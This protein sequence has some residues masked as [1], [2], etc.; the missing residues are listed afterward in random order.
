MIKTKQ[1]TLYGVFQL[2]GSIGEISELNTQ[3]KYFGKK[4]G[5]LIQ[6]C[7]TLDDAKKSAKKRRSFLGK[8]ERQYY[9][10]TYRI[11]KL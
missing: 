10:M 2:G 5:R 4:V 6:T 8:F 1:K 3:I 7:D 11:A 9:K